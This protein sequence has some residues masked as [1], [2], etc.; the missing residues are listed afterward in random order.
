MSN[1]IKRL[2][3]LWV[4]PKPILGILWPLLHA[5]KLLVKSQKNPT[6]THTQPT[7]QQNPPPNKQRKPPHPPNNN[8]N[9]KNPNKMRI[10]KKKKKGG[11]KC[12]CTPRTTSWIFHW[13]TLAIT[14]A[15]C[16]E[17]DGFFHKKCFEGRTKEAWAFGRL[18]EIAVLRSSAGVNQ[19]NCSIATSS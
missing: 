8:N 7:N 16:L 4:F 14:M 3:C 1:H 15:K 12:D 18:L 17:T 2:T 11:K 13:W 9:Q 5:K 6:K 10:K 19:D